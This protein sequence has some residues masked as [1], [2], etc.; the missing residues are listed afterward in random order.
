MSGLLILSAALAWPN[1]AAAQRDTGMAEALRAEVELLQDSGQLG[2]EGIDV[3][4]PDTV[5]AIYLSNRF[6]PVWTDTARVEGLLRTVRDIE[7]EGLSPS[8]YRLGHIESIVQIRTEDQPLTGRAAAVS[9]ILLTD[10]LSR[11]YLD[12]RFGRTTRG[13]R[14]D[15]MEACAIEPAV[16]IRL[17]AESE[18]M[19]DMLASALPR[20]PR[21]IRLRDALREHLRI[22]AEGLFGFHPG[23]EGQGLAG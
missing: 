2:Y 8:D 11:L 1:I 7:N 19:Q 15:A 6:T 14:A 23:T 21:Y 10:S 9:D 18:S 4:E 5:A 16:L 17:L 20:S 22:A 13:T 3:L 12:L